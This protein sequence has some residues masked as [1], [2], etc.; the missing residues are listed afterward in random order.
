MS[1]AAITEVPF[2]DLGC[3][4]RPIKERV[5]ERFGELIDRGEFGNGAAV[6]EF[7]ERF[8]AWCGREQCVGTASGLDALRL[9]LE[10]AAVEPGDEILVPANTFIATFEA[11]TQAGAV[12]V[13]IDA[14]AADY[15]VDVAQ[16]DAAITQRTRAVLPVH[17][18]GQM[19]DMR[20]I[21]EIAERTRLFVL[22]DA[23]QAHGA[24]RDGLRAGDA[25][26]AAAFSFYPAKNVG[27]MGDAGAVVTDDAELAAR[28]RMLREHGQE[29]KY[30]HAAP[31]WTARM[32]AFQ[33][34]V[35]VEKLAQADAW[36]AERRA[37]ASLYG[38]LLAGVGDLR[39]PPVPV[40][41]E[42]VWH[43]YVV[44]TSDPEALVAFLRERG[45]GTGRHYPQPPHLSRA[46]A[47]LGYRAGAFP[48]SEHLAAS[49]VS[50]PIFPGMREDQVE[51]VA[52][53][54]RDYFAG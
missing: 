45:V 24:A 13:P 1:R 51:T 32:D 14:S 10:A 4:N 16:V 17:L 42:P 34:V 28:I 36:T 23:C 54:V 49:L 35:L 52:A 7:E 33:A 43:L 20:A 11:I 29:R 26:A 25:A 19:A 39:L 44:S 27:A 9:A 53:A 38:E 40:G 2:V 50:L 12:P 30:V 48:V 41:S 22:E 21:R 5:L 46:Y 8:A 15:N 47:Y 6:T 3:V 37:V 18:Y 31:G